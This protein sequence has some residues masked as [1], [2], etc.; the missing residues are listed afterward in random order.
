M[1]SII[2]LSSSYCFSQHDKENKKDYQLNYEEFITH[3]GVDDT[4]IAIIDVFFDKR[5]NCAGGK[6][7]L[8]SLSAGIAV[9]NASIGVGLMAVSTPLFLSGT[10]T[11]I[12]YS[13]RHLLKA[14]IN[15]QNADVLTVNLKQRVVTYL[16]IEADCIQEEIENT[17]LA[18]YKTIK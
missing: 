3:Y 13:R 5:Q 17:P 11:R 8:L 14:L 18:T 16:E 9:L 1:I 2:V 15:Y 10:I 4:S 12:K 6:M 7:S